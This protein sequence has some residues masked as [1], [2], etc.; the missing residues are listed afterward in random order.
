[1]QLPVQADPPEVKELAEKLRA[2]E[3]LWQRGAM[4]QKLSVIEAS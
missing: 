4:A 1:M 3:P 2:I